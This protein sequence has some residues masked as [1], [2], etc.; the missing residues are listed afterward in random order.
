MIFNPG[1]EII[2]SLLKFQGLSTALVYLLRTAQ[3][4]RS[5]NLTFSGCVNELVPGTGFGFPSR[6]AALPIRSSVGY[7]VQCIIVL[8]PHCRVVASTVSQNDTFCHF[9]LPFITTP[10]GLDSITYRSLVTLLIE[11]AALRELVG[12]WRETPEMGHGWM[13]VS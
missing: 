5:L 13:A 11:A 3:T 4:S 9:T 7:E 2:N 8:V 12:I 6:M 1:R 10:A